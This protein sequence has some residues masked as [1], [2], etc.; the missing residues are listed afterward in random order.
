MKKHQRVRDGQSNI[1]KLVR[2]Y[3]EEYTGPQTRPI[4]EPEEYNIQYNPNS[5]I[6]EQIVNYSTPEVRVPPPPAP[7]MRT[8]FGVGT[9]DAPA[10]GSAINRVTNDQPMHMRLQPETVRL[11]TDGQEISVI[12]PN[13]YN[14]ARVARETQNTNPSFI[15]PQ[16]SDSRFVRD[17]Y[18]TDQPVQ[19]MMNS[20]TGPGR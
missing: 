6:V 16:G 18:V 10:A 2:E 1:K 8:D 14:A 20:N 13:A 17:S 11:T 3:K 5:Y 19:P 7:P 4:V 15:L 9:S 12:D